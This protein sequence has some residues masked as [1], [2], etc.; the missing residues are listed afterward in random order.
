MLASC[1]TRTAPAPRLWLVPVSGA[2]PVAITPQRGVSSPD[3]G[4]LDGWRL[5]SG[6]YVQGAEACGAVQIFRQT[7]NGSVTLVPVPGATG[8]DNWVVTA[9]G[10]RLLVQAQTSCEGSNS[11]LWFNPATHAEQWLLRTPPTEV[12]VQSVVVYY[13]QENAS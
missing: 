2:K 8:N 6:L 12:G 3:A 13:S 5:P 10:S 7:A 1:Y 11:L 4:D 9:S